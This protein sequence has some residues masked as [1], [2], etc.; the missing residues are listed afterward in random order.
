MKRLHP[1]IV[2]TL[3]ALLL[4]GAFQLPDLHHYFTLDNF[5][6]RHTYYSALYSS[7]PLLTLT[8]YFLLYMLLTALS[9]PGLSVLILIGASLFDFSTTLLVTSFADVFGSVLA[10]FSSRYLV[11]HRLQSRYPSR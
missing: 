11:G 8:L 3:V 6:S 5:R 1:I 7:Y 2:A 10:F 9:I 4:I